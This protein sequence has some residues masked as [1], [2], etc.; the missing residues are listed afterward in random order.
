[1]DNKLIVGI[2]DDK[3]FSHEEKMKE[4]NNEYVEHVP[5]NILGKVHPCGYGAAHHSKNMKMVKQD[6]KI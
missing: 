4:M 2:P 3:Y 1:M 5:V 6:L